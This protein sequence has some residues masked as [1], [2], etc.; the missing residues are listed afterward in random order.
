MRRRYEP[1]ALL[2][3]IPQSDKDDWIRKIELS[4]YNYN[5][6]RDL[7]DVRQRWEIVPVPNQVELIEWFESVVVHEDFQ[8]E[9]SHLISKLSSRSFFFWYIPVITC[10]FNNEVGN[11]TPVIGEGLNLKRFR[12]D[13]NIS[14]EKKHGVGYLDIQIFSQ[15]E[16]AD[17]EEL[18][19]VANYELRGLEVT[20][21]WRGDDL[22]MLAILAN[23][24]RDPNKK[25][26]SYGQFSSTLADLGYTR[27]NGGFYSDDAI[28][29]K[30]KKALELGF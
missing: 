5:F 11:L 10:I 9:L 26:M 30:I 24:Y 1:P 4:F 29:K 21:A 6:L 27:K 8:I 13:F 14:L 19:K 18:K 15:L 28:Q 22:R 12:G 23:L 20:S 2:P 25:G 17:W 16:D 7:E 3:D